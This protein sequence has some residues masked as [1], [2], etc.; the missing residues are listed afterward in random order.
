LFIK[1]FTHNSV[2]IDF[3][4]LVRR[5]QQTP[6]QERPQGRSMSLKETAQNLKRAANSRKDRRESRTSA[7]KGRPVDGTQKILSWSFFKRSIRERVF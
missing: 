3:Y 1:I 6:P 4:L 7:E 2:S 5:P